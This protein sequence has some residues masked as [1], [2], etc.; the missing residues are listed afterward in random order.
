ML[1]HAADRLF[2]G[3]RPLAFDHH[4][5]VAEHGLDGLARRAI[6]VLDHDADGDEPAYV[7]GESFGGPIALALTRRWPERV[8]GLLLFSTFAHY[9]RL[10]AY[11]GAAGITLGRMLSR[12]QGDGAFRAGRPL[13]VPGQLGFSPSREVLRQYFER[14]PAHLPSYLQK[15]ELSLMLDERD[16]LARLTQP[17]FVLVGSWDPVVPTSCGRELARLI[18]RAELHRVTGGHLVHLVE[19]DRVGQLVAR[20]IAETAQAEAASPARAPVA[21]LPSRSLPAAH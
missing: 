5:D 13:T 20:W 14:P 2:P 8:R 1:M 6:D 11:G 15:C 16:S 3:L 19:A 9:P 10:S 21:A 7:C 4:G 18:P 12:R 17:A